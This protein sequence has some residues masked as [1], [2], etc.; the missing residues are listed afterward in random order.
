LTVV[1]VL[2]LSLAETGEAA[3]QTLPALLWQTWKFRLFMA[4]LL[5]ALLA[6]AYR[7]RVRHLLE[8]ERLR[9][10][11]AS[12]LHDDVGSNL[13]SIALLSEM[14]RERLDRD[15]LDQRQLA[16]ITAAAE[17]T[18]GALRD[19]IWL[20]NPSHAAL[21]DLIR[22]MR[23]VAADLLNGIGVSFDVDEPPTR[24]I[25]MDFMRAALLV[26]KE[27]LHNVSRHAGASKVEV[28][29]RTT[30]RVLEFSVED[31]GIGFNVDAPGG[32]YGVENMRRRAWQAGGTV[33]I[34]SAH[35]AGTC[36]TFSAPMA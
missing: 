31:D 28:R 36:V 1:F 2:A 8:L 34:R 35:S 22:K 19:I 30:D 25:S 27:A 6:A 14:L 29:I 21:E 23:V 17:E 7:L 10:R 11:I 18:I 5:V 4:A 15:E 12:D 9:L 3:A 26:Y 16:R 32:G 13:S 33:E 24:R 20:V